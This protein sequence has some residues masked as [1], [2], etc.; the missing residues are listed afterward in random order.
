MIEH[1]EFNKEYLK[2]LTPKF[3]DKLMSL[4]YY[5]LQD[6]IMY[7]IDLDPVGIQINAISIYIGMKTF[8]YTLETVFVNQKTGK[9]ESSSID[10]VFAADKIE[11]AR[12]YSENLSEEFLEIMPALEKNLAVQLYILKKVIEETEE[13]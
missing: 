13:D 5:A 8:S 9:C 3:M 2:S 6:D 1:I 10:I 4:S 12:I 7:L 11:S